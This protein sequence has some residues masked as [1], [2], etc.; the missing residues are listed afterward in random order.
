MVYNMKE[1]SRFGGAI[2]RQASQ[3]Y[4]FWDDTD[5]QNRLGQKEV[6]LKEKTLGLCLQNPLPGGVKKDETDK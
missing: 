1:Q 2:S 4:A 3:Y 6:A 5:P